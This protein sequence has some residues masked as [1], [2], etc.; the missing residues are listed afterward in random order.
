MPESNGPKVFE[1]SSANLFASL[2][3]QWCSPND[4]AESRQASYLYGYLDSLQAKTIVVEQHYLD[5]DYLEDFAAYYVRCFKPYE[6]VCK[7][8]HFFSIAISDGDLRSF[9]LGQMGR[10]KAEDVRAS[11]IGFCVARPLPNAIIGRTIVATYPEAAADGRQ[12]SYTVVRDYDAHLF[13]QRLVVRG[14]PFQEQDTVLAACATV[15]LWCAFHKTNELFGT[16]APRPAQITQVASRAGHRGR[17][18]PSHG[19]RI[20]EMCDVTRSVGLEPEL[21]EWEG[22]FLPWVSLAYG[23]LRAGLPV[24]LIVDIK[25]ELHAITLTGYS[26]D[27]K[28]AHQ[29]EQAG[30]ETAVPLT[31]LR[32]YEFYGHDDQVGP[33][34]KHVIGSSGS[35]PETLSGSWMEGSQFLELIP[36]GALI[37]VYNKVRVTFY[38]AL[39]WVT[40][41]H[42]AL[43]ILVE[44]DRA[45]F[46]WDVY[47]T[48]TNDYK[49]EALASELPAGQ[50]E[51]LLLKAQPRFLWQAN[52]YVHDERVIHLLIDATDIAR[53]FPLQALVCHDE[54]F[55]DDAY[56]LLTAGELQ[57]QLEDGLG[58]ELLTFLKKTFEPAG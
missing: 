9:I 4:A 47:L 52:L 32:V 2:S 50:V 31:G 34:A 15:S 1:F 42:S 23:Y 56:A 11:Y 10:R 45:E 43:G 44:D 49:R 3:N 12:R 39:Q 40:L 54:G 6:R 33:H 22:G 28:R 21:V 36:V 51:D 20:E 35:A 46:E 8:L 24:V 29:R 19:L 48:T 38:E 17:P 37:P 57:Q 13:G 16:Q 25:G 27:S 41:I 58:R 26:L 55:A 53:S 18:I 7:R 5:G 30:K 14:L